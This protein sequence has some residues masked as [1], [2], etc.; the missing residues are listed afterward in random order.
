V[1]AGGTAPYTYA[2]SYEGTAVSFTNPTSATT[3]FY[4]TL[5]QGDIINGSAVCRVT[6]STPGPVGPNISFMEIEWG[7]NSNWLNP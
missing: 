2:W 4:N 6:D 1:A 5:A 7:M 3:T